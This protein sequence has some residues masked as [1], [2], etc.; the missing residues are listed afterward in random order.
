[1]PT[2]E[3]PA[4]R[5]VSVPLGFGA[6][7]TDL[8]GTSIDPIRTT[9]TALT[10]AGVARGGKRSDIGNLRGPQRVVTERSGRGPRLLSNRAIRDPTNVLAGTMFL[11]RGPFTLR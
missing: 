5:A 1:M 7:T 3:Q 2:Y 10:K 6:N 9:D 11:G 8:Q 4:G